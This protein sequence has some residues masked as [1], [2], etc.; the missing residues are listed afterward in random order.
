LNL[1][2]T[3][4][5]MMIIIVIYIVL[6]VGASNMWITPSNSIKLSLPTCV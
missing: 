4:V 5:Y 1:F 6:V 2:I 3:R